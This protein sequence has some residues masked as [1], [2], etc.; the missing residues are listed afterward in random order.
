MPQPIREFAFITP[1]DERT[2]LVFVPFCT[3]V[4]LFAPTNP[5]RSLFRR[6]FMGLVA[7]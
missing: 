2:T 6:L 4:K 3:S 7:S 1:A 5:A